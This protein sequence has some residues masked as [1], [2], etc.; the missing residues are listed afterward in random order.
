LKQFKVSKSS[1]YF[2]YSV[3]TIFIL[4]ILIMSPIIYRSED[5]P[6]GKVFFFFWTVFVIIGVYMNIRMPHS[7]TLNSD[8]GKIIFNSLISK[9]K[10]NIREIQKIKTSPINSAYITFRHKSGRLTLLNRIDGLHELI[11][12]IKKV[13]PNLETKGC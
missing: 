1:L 11:N 10:V 12:E 4:V 2:T 9:K 13:N 3:M 8:S 5:D 6:E 7:M